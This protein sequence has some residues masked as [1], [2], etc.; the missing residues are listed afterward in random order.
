MEHKQRFKLNFSSQWSNGQFFYLVLAHVQPD[1]P[2]LVAL[3]EVVGD[4][5]GQLRLPDSGRPEKEED[6]RMLVVDPS[7]LL[8][9]NGRRDD[10]DG[11]VLKLKLS[12]KFPISI[13]SAKKQL[14]AVS[15]LRR[16]SFEFTTLEKSLVHFRKLIF[17][18]LSEKTTR[19]LRLNPL[20]VLMN[21]NDNRTH[22]IMIMEIFSTCPTMFSLSLF[23][24]GNLLRSLRSRCCCRWR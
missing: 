13:T 17:S 3:V 15:F 8:P 4:L 19:T 12:L 24:S 1:E 22:K 5:L 18:L 21:L 11:P 23:S 6:E 16:Q 2:L 10:R 14:L 7:V 20:L 9:A